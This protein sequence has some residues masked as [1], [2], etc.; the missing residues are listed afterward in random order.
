MERCLACEADRGGGPGGSRLPN[1]QRVLPE[2]D[3]LNGLTTRAY[4]LTLAEPRFYGGF[5][6][7]VMPHPRPAARQIFGPNAVQVRGSFLDAGFA[8]R[9]FGSL[10]LPVGL[11]SEAALHGLA[12]ILSCVSSRKA[13]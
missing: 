6:L 13:A 9:S 7:C 5:S 12:E 10:A 8:Y 2:G 3:M 1:D 4:V 11:A